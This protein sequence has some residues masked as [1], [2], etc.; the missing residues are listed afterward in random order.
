M[1]TLP[2]DWFVCLLQRKPY[3]PVPI[4]MLL[5][6]KWMADG[7]TLRWNI[8]AITRS[9]S[10]FSCSLA[11]VGWESS[12]GSMLPNLVFSLW[13]GRESGF[14]SL[15]WFFRCLLR[16]WKLVDVRR[17]SHGCSYVFTLWRPMREERIVRLLQR[18]QVACQ[19][20]VPIGHHFWFKM[21]ISARLQ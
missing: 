19:I 11:I 2:I 17:L 13:V 9:A 16:R 21:S 18:W 7:L 12:F 1:N 10:L 4:F 20:N 5:P 3:E 8:R 6:R 15:R 14:C